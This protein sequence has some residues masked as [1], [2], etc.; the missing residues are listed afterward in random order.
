MKAKRQDGYRNS[1]A[2][3]GGV[4]SRWFATGG[5]RIEDFAVSGLTAI[6]DRRL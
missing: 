3:C 4:G 5:L 1:H 6:D 2:F